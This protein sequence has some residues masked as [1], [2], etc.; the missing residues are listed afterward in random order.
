MV[1]LDLGLGH[2][3][4][5]FYQSMEAEFEIISPDVEEYSRREEAQ[6]PTTKGN[7]EGLTRFRRKS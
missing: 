4:E 2:K 6:R 1:K 5:A 7:P 3:E